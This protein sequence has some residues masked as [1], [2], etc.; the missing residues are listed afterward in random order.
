MNWKK[1]GVYNILALL[2][3]TPLLASLVL[4]QVTPADVERFSQGTVDSIASFFN[5]ILKWLIGPSTNSAE[6][7]LKVLAFL[8]VTIVIYGLMD[9]IKILGEGADKR[10]LNFAIGIIVATIGIRFIPD[11]LLTALTAPSSA[12][13]AIIVLG[14]PFLAMFFILKKLTSSTARRIAWVMYAILIITIA[15]YN[16]GLMSW[17]IGN[18]TID[19]QIQT[20]FRQWGIIYVVF[21]AVALAMALLDGTI[22]RFFRGVEAEKYT[23]NVLDEKGDRLLEKKAFYETIANDTNVPQAKRDNALRQIGKIN[24][25]LSSLDSQQSSEGRRGLKGIWRI[26]IILSVIIAAIFIGIQIWNALK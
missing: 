24:A 4:A 25:A 18:Y 12:F 6:I 13:V 16:A 1:I 3:I 2:M 14:I 19:S 9:S 26:L 10:W 22:Q 17:L 5:P 11:N 21:G 8:L 15:V 23:G 20:A 7:A